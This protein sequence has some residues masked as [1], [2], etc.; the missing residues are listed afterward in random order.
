MRLRGMSLLSSGREQEGLVLFR[1]CLG[2]VDDLVQLEFDAQ[3]GAAAVDVTGTKATFY[4]ERTY[5]HREL[6]L[7]CLRRDDRQGARHHFGQLMA[8]STDSILRD[9]EREVW[10]RQPGWK[11]EL[12]GITPEGVGQSIEVGIGHFRRGAFDEACVEFETALQSARCQGYG[13]QEGRAL[14]NLAT[15]NMKRG[16]LK[17]AL[18]QYKQCALLLRALGNAA[19]EKKILSFFVLCCIEA[20]KWHHA[21]AFNDLLLELV[22]SRRT[23]AMLQE[24]SLAIASH[25]KSSR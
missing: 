13:A 25:R 22:D 24:R 6:G 10:L 19:T 11:E 8:C 17:T 4:F 12:E 3:E 15:A 16:R 20:G 5:I 1:E 18:L 23:L 9:S 2:K 21:K 14:S 7:D